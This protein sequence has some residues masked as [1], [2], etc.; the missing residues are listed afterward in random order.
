VSEL[1]AQLPGYFGAH[2]LLTTF[3]LLAAISISL[4][5]GI[6]CVR[7]SFRSIVLGAASV[8]QTIP[9]LALLALMVL[10]LR[11]FGFWPAFAALVLYGLLPILRNTLTGI[12][13]VD[14]D[15]VD[16]ARAMGMTD[17]QVLVEVEL[18]LALPVIVAGIR[19][20]AVWIVGIATLSTPVGQPSL[21]NYIFAGLQTR[22]FQS[23]LLGC[24]CA[25]FLAVTLDLILGAL[26]R[27]SRK[28][29]KK[30]GVLAITALAAMLGFGVA[31]P[32]FGPRA[33]TPPAAPA[34]PETSD[35]PVA[36]TLRVGAKTFTEQYILASL[37]QERLQKAGFAVE[38]LDSL[39]STIVFD[40]LVQNRIDVYVDYTGTI[41]ANHMK[42]DTVAPAWRV[43]REVC[44]WLAA[45]HGV[46]CLGALGFENAYALAMRRD[47]AAALGIR[48]IDD[49]AK[50]ATELEIGGDYEFF[51]RPEWTKLKQSY[52]LAFSRTQSFDPSF[53][54][55]AVSERAV[56]V[57]SAFSSDGRIAALDLV[58]LSDPR[59][60][61]PP[62]DAILMVGP[63]AANDDRV[64]SALLPLVNHIPVANMREANWLVDR[65]KNKKSPRDAAVWLDDRLAH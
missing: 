40:A 55:T 35:T 32:A 41:W 49:L 54:Y 62:Y 48:S 56:D 44:G 59:H 61:F 65:E 31:A 46:R 18:P 29:E 4:P 21:G 58:V 3:A 51:Q 64:A 10:A 52:G 30:R 12:E 6:V 11:S 13:G 42:R 14:A 7:S 22:N 15:V 26:E 38:R 25:A 60:A 17:R 27:A 9:G 1:L 8:L 36:R 33:P 24:V 43:E 2:V 34:T 57:I 23:V 19:T 50:H 5:L 37:L 16:A 53:M 47:R 45:T 63:L 39:G 20:A 28:R